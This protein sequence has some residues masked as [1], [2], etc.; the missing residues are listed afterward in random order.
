MNNQEEK[1]IPG[2]VVTANIKIN[3]YESVIY[4][5]N[6]NIRSRY[7]EYYIYTVDEEGLARRITIERGLVI[8]NENTIIRSGL[9]VGD[10]IVVEGIDSLQDG[11]KVNIRS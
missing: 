3:L 11:A 10:R 8:N 9:N 7:D 1:L 4:T 2:M 5:D 6:S